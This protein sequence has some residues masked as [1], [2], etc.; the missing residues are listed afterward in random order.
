MRGEPGRQ[1]RLDRLGR[2]AEELGARIDLR[3]AREA[4]VAPCFGGRG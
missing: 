2:V 3:E 1:D 4:P